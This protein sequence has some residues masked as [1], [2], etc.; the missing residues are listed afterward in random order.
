MAVVIKNMWANGAQLGDIFAMIAK[1]SNL[2]LNPKKCI[3]IPLWAYDLESLKHQIAKDLN[4]CE[5]FSIQD[6]GKYLGFLVG[7]KAHEQQWNKL[8]VAHMVRGLGLPNLHSILMFNMLGVSKVAHLAQLKCPDKSVSRVFKKAERMIIGG[9]YNWLTK[10]GEYYQKSQSKFPVQLKDVKVLC[11]ASMLRTAWVTLPSW[12]D[13]DRTF[14]LQAQ[15]DN[16]NLVHAHPD[17]LKDASLNSLQNIHGSVHRND[18][19]AFFKLQ[20]ANCRDN[21]SVVIKQHVIYDLLLA[22]LSPFCLK[23]CL[24]K[25]FAKRNWFGRDEVDRYATLAVSLLEDIHKRVPPCILFAVLNTFFN[26]WTT[27][28]RFQE[29]EDC[30]YLCNICDGQDSIEHYASCPHMWRCFANIS[31]KSCLPM[32]MGRFLG[33][34]AHSVEDKILYACNMYATRSAV[35]Q[36]RKYRFVSGPDKLKKLLWTFSKKPVY[37]TKDLENSLRELCSRVFTIL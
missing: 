20:H 7:P 34:Y 15:D 5:G 26:G 30:C 37:T 25:R 8:K 28:A 16:S 22:K 31:S 6:F 12:R 14:F 10:N 35:N 23:S 33:L 18:Y 32:S 36:R 19:D 21:V 3:L 9:P 24:A 13:L 11:Q 1:I 29:V 27:S 17:W 2:C 4:W